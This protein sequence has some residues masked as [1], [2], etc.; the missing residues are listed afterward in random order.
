[1][2]YVQI[3]LTYVRLGI[4]NELEYRAN[5]FVQIAYM[6]LQLIV[7]L[8]GMSV[9]YS[10]TNTLNG[11]TSAEL[12][13][14]VGVYFLFG[15]Y[16]HLIV[17]PSLSQFLEDIRM[18]TLDFVLTKPADAQVLVSVRR[19]V[20]WKLLDIAV[21]FGLLMVALVQI[22]S[23]VGLAQVIG[24]TLSLLFGAAIVYS[25]WLMLATIAFWFVKIDN[26]LVIFESMY[27]AGRYPVGVYPLWLRF[28]LT[29]LIPIAFAVT[30][31]A[32]AMTQ[33]LDTLSLAVSAVLAVVLLLVSRWFWRLGVK[34][35][36]G[37][38][39]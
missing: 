3:I 15:G 7:S 22:G 37:A 8:G 31:P 33:R 34:N 1:M 13:A 9:I 32:E 11:W 12:L 19:V 25:V 2:R 36:T 26:I 17:Q 4:L 10:H 16:I 39:A 29:F 18:G 30:V 23:S 24:F 35:Y 28:I 27:E 38:S 5:F 21:G 14:V 20:I 6:V